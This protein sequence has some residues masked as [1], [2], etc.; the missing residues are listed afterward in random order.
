MY[1]D[2]CATHSPSWKIQNPWHTDVHNSFMPLQ[3]ACSIHSRGTGVVLTRVWYKATN[4]VATGAVPVHT[5]WGRSSPPTHVCDALPFIP[6]RYAQSTILSRL[7]AEEACS[8]ELV[9]PAW[10]LWSQACSRFP[11]IGTFSGK[12]TTAYIVPTVHAA[13]HGFCFCSLNAMLGIAEA[14]RHMISLKAGSSVT[15]ETGHQLLL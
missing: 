12:E 4:D 15:V 10:S 3:C 7:W 8:L 5:S 11:C 6:W 14:S 13:R 2:S 9:L 1:L